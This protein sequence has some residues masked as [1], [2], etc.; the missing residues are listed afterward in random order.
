MGAYSVPETVPKLNINSLLSSNELG[1]FIPILQIKIVK[2][3][4]VN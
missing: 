4:K 2:L 1:I 3:S